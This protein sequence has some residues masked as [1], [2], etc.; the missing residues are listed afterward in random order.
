[1][2]TNQAVLVLTLTL[3]VNADSRWSS[4]I[5]IDT[6]LRETIEHLDSNTNQVYSLLEE[7]DS[8]SRGQDNENK[9][10]SRFLQSDLRIDYRAGTRKGSKRSS[11]SEDNIFNHG[12]GS[13]SNSYS[14]SNSN[15][16]LYRSSKKY[17]ATIQ[18]PT[19][20]PQTH[21]PQTHPPT[22]PTP[23]TTGSPQTPFPTQETPKEIPTNPPFF[24]PTPTPVPTGTISPNTK[25]VVNNQGLFGAQIGVAEVIP[26]GYEITVFGTPSLEEKISVISVMEESITNAILDDLFLQCS[27]G[28]VSSVEEEAK[29]GQSKRVHH[30]TSDRR[31]QQNAFSGVSSRPKDQVEDGKLTSMVVIV[32]LS[33]YHD[34]LLLFYYC[35]LA[36]LHLDSDM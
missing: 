18:T 3:L 36:S 17:G 5:H 34:C 29:E 13:S 27:S 32:C 14:N 31:L 19:H 33:N 10:T 22:P 25:C 26:F 20:P 28:S 2:M 11:G 15:S 30:H 24:R 21:P 23:T 16:Y 9:G 1:M 7:T 6:N 4:S 12:K 35:I 8:G